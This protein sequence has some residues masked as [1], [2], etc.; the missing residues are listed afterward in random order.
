MPL[1][2]IGWVAIVSGSMAWFL[3]AWWPLVAGMTAEVIIVK[4][5]EPEAESEVG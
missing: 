5:M 3:D 1:Y 4:T 2:V